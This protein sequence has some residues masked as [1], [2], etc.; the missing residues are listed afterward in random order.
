MKKQFIFWVHICGLISIIY[1]CCDNNIRSYQVAQTV[2]DE[3]WIQ[4]LMVYSKYQIAEVNQMV[5]PIELDNY[6]NRYTHSFVHPSFTAA[7]PFFEGKIVND[8][9]FTVKMEN[10]TFEVQRWSFENEQLSRIF[11]DI[12]NMY[13]F[14]RRFLNYQV[15]AKSVLYGKTVYFVSSSNQSGLDVKLNHFCQYLSHTLYSH[16]QIKID[17]T[18]VVDDVDVNKEW[19]K[20][21]LSR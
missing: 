21:N 13:D 20:N 10:Y 18:I 19:L 7:K 17:S 2:K 11:N 14:D 1:S 3:V 8:L 15:R 16:T 12:F 4:Q 6:E 9:S 5:I